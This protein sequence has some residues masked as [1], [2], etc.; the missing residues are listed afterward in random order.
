MDLTAELL[1]FD[2][3]LKF[4]MHY[5]NEIESIRK[6]IMT[7]C[8]IRVSIKNS[9]NQDMSSY[10]ADLSNSPRS[11]IQQSVCTCNIFPD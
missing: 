4:A 6:K 5:I 1:L 8:K 11:Y 9:S 7:N 10:V 2:E 3:F